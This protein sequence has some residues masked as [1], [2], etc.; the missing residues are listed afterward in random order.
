MCLGRSVDPIEPF[1]ETCRCFP[2]F[3][4][5]NFGPCYRTYCDN[6]WYDCC[7]CPDR[8]LQSV[9]FDEDEKAALV[10]DVREYLYSN[11][12][13]FYNERASRS[14]TYRDRSEDRG[15]SHRGS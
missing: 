1:T 12:T 9:H 6:S 2:H 7:L 5:V 10:K 15:H 3:S 4:H 14:R 8:S 11:T 13:R